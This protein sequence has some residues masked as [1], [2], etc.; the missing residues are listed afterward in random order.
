L[1]LN[2]QRIVTN[3]EGDSLESWNSGDALN[4]SLRHRKLPHS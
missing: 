2:E 1:P 3:A 4:H